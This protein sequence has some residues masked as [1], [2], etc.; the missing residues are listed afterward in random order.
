MYSSSGLSTDGFL[1]RRIYTHSNAG[2]TLLHSWQFQHKSSSNDALNL[3]KV[4]KCTVLSPWHITVYK[5]QL[6]FV[7][8]FEY[9]L[10]QNVVD[11]CREQS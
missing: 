11:K 4:W 6:I 2:K 3:F 10:W 7:S 9:I 8:A 5:V 1:I